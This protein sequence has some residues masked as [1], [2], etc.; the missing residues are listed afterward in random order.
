MRI[1]LILVLIS[2]VVLPACQRAGSDAPRLIARSQ[3]VLLS[4]PTEFITGSLDGWLFSA[5]GGATTIEFSYTP[6]GQE[7]TD[8]VVPGVTLLLAQSDSHDGVRYLLVGTLDAAER[9]S[10]HRYHDTSGDGAPDAGTQSLLFT[11]VEP[12]YVT[13]LSRTAAGTTY[14]LD[15]R[16]QDILV[17][18]DSDGDAWPDQIAAAPFARSA[19][20]E[21]LLDAGFIRMLSNG[22]LLAMINARMERFHSPHD[23]FRDTD[24]DL[25]ADVHVVGPEGDKPIY[26]SAFL[27]VGQDE[28]TVAAQVGNVVEV[29]ELDSSGATNVLLGSATVASNGRATISLTRT[30]AAGDEIGIKYASSTEIAIT[31]TVIAKIPQVLDV[32]PKTALTNQNSTIVLTGQDFTTTMTVT[33]REMDGTTHTLTVQYIDTTTVNVTVPSLT[34]EGSVAIYAHEPGQDLEEFGVRGRTIQVCNPQ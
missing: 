27:S 17:A 32:E 33:L 5:Q 9:Y 22:N 13:Y 25:V 18:T 28:L 16:C 10:L 8:L 31:N 3:V 19:D 21:T 4:P 6:G 23:I 7:D 30:L 29:W 12:M 11:S 20:H 24:G 2:A 14:L 34:T 1:R 15:K 26:F